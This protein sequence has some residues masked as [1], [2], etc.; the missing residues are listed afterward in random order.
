MYP[1][2]QI[3][4]SIRASDPPEEKQLWDR[5]S[6]IYRSVIATEAVPIGYRFVPGPITISGLIKASELGKRALIVYLLLHA[7][8]RMASVGNKE[9]A[10][11]PTREFQRF[12]MDS[13]SKARAITA[14]EEAGLVEVKREGRKSLKLRTIK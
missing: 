13:A 9:W 8:E 12:K 10:S 2:K 7:A 1:S 14:L 3:A 4:A 11:I 6:R 5:Q